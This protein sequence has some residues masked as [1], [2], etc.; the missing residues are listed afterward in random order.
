MRYRMEA[1]ATLN[2]RSG[3]R[4]A[5]PVRPQDG[6]GGSPISTDMPVGYSRR[7]DGSRCDKGRVARNRAGHHPDRTVEHLARETRRR[8]ARQIVT[9][10][11]TSVRARGR[12]PRF[13]EW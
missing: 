4:C 7:R 11:P 13:C 2:R 5:R 6:T 10:T 1:P 3:L 12:R 9:N 8:G